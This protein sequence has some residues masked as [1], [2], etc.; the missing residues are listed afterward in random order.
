MQIIKGDKIAN[1]IIE[2]LA[3][4]VKMLPSDPTLAVILIGNNKQSRKYIEIKEKIAEKIGVN[5]KLFEFSENIEQ[6]NIVYLID[7]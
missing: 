7:E 6:S 4:E 1:E 5:F 3:V 2:E